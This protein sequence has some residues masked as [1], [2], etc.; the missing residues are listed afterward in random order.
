MNRFAG[1]PIYTEERKYGV[2]LIDYLGGKY[3]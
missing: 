3:E 2:L 1:K